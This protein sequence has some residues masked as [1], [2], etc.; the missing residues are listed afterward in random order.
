[1]RCH[2]AARTRWR[3]NDAFTT[4][5]AIYAAAFR[6][7]PAAGDADTARR[8]TLS[9]RVSEGGDDALPVLRFRGYPGQGFAAD[10]RSRRDPAAPLLPELRGPLHHLRARPAAR[11]DGG[12]EERAARTLRARQARAR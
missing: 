1:M 9:G 8:G 4:R 12:Q 11:A 5:C 6:S 3:R 10:R 2:A 7:T